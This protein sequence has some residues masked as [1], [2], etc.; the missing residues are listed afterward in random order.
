MPVPG[1]KSLWQAQEK[2]QWESLYD[3]WLQDCTG[4]CFLMRELMAKPA[5]SSDR[6]AKLQSWLE[7]VDEFGLMLMMVVDGCR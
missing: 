6:E 2:L 3:S 5:P 1:A 7:N 4:G